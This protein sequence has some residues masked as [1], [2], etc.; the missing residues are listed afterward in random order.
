MGYES[1]AA[2]LAA[3]GHLGQAAAQAKAAQDVIDTQHFLARAIELRAKGYSEKEA[4]EMLDSEKA[5][6]SQQRKATAEA[7][8]GPEGTAARS[9]REKQLELASRGITVAGGPGKE[10][11]RGE[12]VKMQ[13]QDRFRATFSEFMQGVE[14]TPENVARAT[15]LAKQSTEADIRKESAVLPGA[16]QVADSLTELGLGGGI[17]EGAKDPNIEVNK[18]IADL[19]KDQN[20]ILADIN[21]KLDLGVK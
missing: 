19:T 16:G 3:T 18:R 10:G 6:L 13:D 1:E 15:D 7:R 11:A 2:R 4:N 14:N 12:L 8:L 9:V 21:K 20:T 5:S 17:Y